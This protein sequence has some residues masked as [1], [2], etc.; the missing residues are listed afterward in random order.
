MNYHFKIHVDK[1]S[2]LLW[3]QCIELEGCFTQAKTLDEL[4]VNMQEAVDL[5]IQE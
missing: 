4:I 1:E 3:A 2:G 5:Y